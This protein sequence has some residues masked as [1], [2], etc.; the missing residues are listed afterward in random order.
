[1]AT[2][3]TQA[4]K[5]I[6]KTF[7]LISTFLIFIIF[8]GWFF[9]QILGNQ[10]ILYLAV[11]FALFQSFL[12]FWYGE[13]IVLAMTGAK[14]IEKKTIQN[15]IGLLRTSALQLVYLC[16]KF[17]FSK[18]TNLMLLRPEEIKSTL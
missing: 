2:L 9:S 17:I 12:S 4:E 1:M 7:I 13:K 11:I 6:R 3:Y 10:I 18:K 14:V 8:L 5:N 16:Q 15:F